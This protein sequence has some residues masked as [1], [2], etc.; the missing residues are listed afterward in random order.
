MRF[1]TMRIGRRHGVVLIPRA[2]MMLLSSAAAGMDWQ[3][4]VIPFGAGFYR[5]A[6]GWPAM[7]G[8]MHGRQ[9]RSGW[10]CPSYAQRGNI[11]TLEH[12]VAG[13]LVLF[14][15][16]SRVKL[17][18]Q[19]AGIVDIVHDSSPI[20]GHTPVGGLYI[21]CAFGTGAHY[22]PRDVLWLCRGMFLRS[23]MSPVHCWHRPI[24]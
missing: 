10:I 6:A 19:W 5:S 16:L 14:P 22:W 21:N 11:G 12:V 18:R 7:T 15:R 9:M 8:A 17:M 1:V 13:V 2:N 4:P 23:K 20:I 24:L 3:R